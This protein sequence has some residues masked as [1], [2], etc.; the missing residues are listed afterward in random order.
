MAV[1]MSGEVPLN[2]KV[3]RHGLINNTAIITVSGQNIMPF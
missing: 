1:L 3:Q 2:I